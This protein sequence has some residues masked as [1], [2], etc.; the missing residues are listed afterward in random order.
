MKAFRCQGCGHSLYFENTAC[1]SCGRR[2]GYLARRQILS[3]LDPAGDE[4][5]ALGA[6]GRAYRFCGNAEYGVCNWMISASSKETLCAACRHNN[7]IPDLNVPGNVELWRRLE[8]AKH[9]LFY[10]LLKLRFPLKNRAEDP[11][12]GLAFDFLGDDTA[13]HGQRV[14]TGH[15]NGLITLALRE[16]DD[17]EREKIRSEMGEPYRALLGHFRHESGHYFWD[18]LVHDGGR[19]DEFRAMFGD[20]RQDYAA[21]LQA[22]YANGPPADWQQNFASAYASAHPW[23]DFAETWAHYLHIV[24]TLET[25]RAF[26]VKTLPSPGRRFSLTRGIDFD[27][28]EAR[29][30]G[31]LIAAW[32]PL[33]FAVNSL[34]RS[35]GHT[36]L[37]P[38]VLTPHVIDKLGFV[39]GLAGAQ[40]AEN[41]S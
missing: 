41:V 23:E 34:N 21:A 14:M 3:A 39:L 29:D 9:R 13:S 12:H 36:D 26:G 24:D 38:F 18:R 8:I 4:W 32:L 1:E 11:Q 16:A 30:I 35:M 20:E 2:L 10:S 5:L 6:R 37:Y 27:P 28:Y 7:F 33:A 15:D 19:L 40:Q 22:H 17:A 31:H 25:A